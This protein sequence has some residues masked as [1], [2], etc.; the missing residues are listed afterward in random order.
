[1]DVV[2]VY[3]KKRSQFGRRP[4]FST[5]EITE[6]CDCEPQPQLSKDHIEISPLHKGIQ[7][8]PELSIHGVSNFI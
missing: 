7:W 5:T 8:V 1:M 4:D 2:Y 3:Q 6:L